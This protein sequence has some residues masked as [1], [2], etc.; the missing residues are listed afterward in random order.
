V[1]V[2][3]RLAVLV[4]GA[5]LFVAGALII[6]E[7]AATGIG[8]RFVWI[9]GQRWLDS[10]Q[11][12]DRSASTVIWTAVVVAVVA[13]LLTIAELRPWPR[14]L[15]RINLGGDHHWWILRRTLERHLARR[16]R[17]DGSR[18]A[19]RG[20]LD[21]RNGIWKL[22]LALRAASSDRPDLEVAAERE[23]VRVGAP[24]HT[25]IILKT[26]RPRRLRD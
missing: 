11:T 12:T 26:K 5:V 13:A 6:V 21:E 22:K 15:V 19:V 18:D 7:V 14:R 8:S 3:N 20:R 9:P 23:L 10:A 2:F 4:G 17:P 16:V 1:R 24:G 25:R